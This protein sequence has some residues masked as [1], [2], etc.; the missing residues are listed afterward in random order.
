VQRIPIVF[1]GAGVRAGHRPKSAMRSVDI[2]PTILRELG[3][4]SSGRLDGKAYP[5]P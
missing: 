2:T 4:R 3:I 1:A 5:L